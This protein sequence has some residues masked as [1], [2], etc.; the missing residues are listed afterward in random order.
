MNAIKKDPIEANKQTIQILQVLR[1]VAATVV[2]LSHYFSEGFTLFGCSFAGSVG[3]G[4]FF[5][6]SGFL[7]IYADKGNYKGYILKRVI[8]I[9]PFYW[10]TTFLVFV[11]GLAA[12]S[13]L[14]TSVSTLSNLLKSLFF[15]PYYSAHGIFPLLTV[16][17]TLVVEM[18]VYLLYYCVVRLLQYV[19]RCRTDY[20]PSLN[21]SAGGITAVILLVLVIL[22]HLLPK[23]IFTFSYGSNYMIYFVIG[24]VG[25]LI[26]KKFSKSFSIFQK[27]CAVLQK[28]ANFVTVLLVAVFVGISAIYVDSIINI[29]ILGFSTCAII[30]IFWSVYFPPI[31]I[32]LGDI[33]YSFYLVHYFVVKLCTRVFMNLGLPNNFFTIF[34]YPVVCYIITVCIAWAGYVI[35]EKKFGAWLKRVLLK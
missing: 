13:L 23:N 11:L 4:I 17:W 27:K 8:R 10:L 15:I 28:T 2:F 31:I 32:K 21:K 20:D 25:A 14:H 29:L 12:P 7:L 35:I 18:F 19:Y 22:N 16:G 3:V 9:C 1:A 26:L 34:F 33:S 24:I 30:A 6:I 5:V